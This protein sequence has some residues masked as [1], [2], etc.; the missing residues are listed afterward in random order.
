MHHESPPPTTHRK[1][2]RL[3]RAVP[4][5]TAA[6]AAACLGFTLLAPTGEAAPAERP[7]AKAGQGPLPATSVADV[8]DPHAGRNDRSVAPISEREPHAA[9]PTEA[10]RKRL[11]ASVKREAKA[12]A[13][14]DVNDFISKTGDELVK[15]IKSVDKNCINSFFSQVGS[16]AQALFKQDQ[17]VTAMNALRDLS[18]DYP[19]DNSTSALQVVLYLRAGYYVQFNHPEDVGE[20]GPELKSASQAAQDAWWASSHVFDVSDENGE[21]L[22]EAVILIDSSS[23]NGRYLNIVKKLLTSYDSSY[24]EFYWMLSSVNNV[25]NVMFLG[26]GQD[27]FLAAVKD[28]PSVLNN[29]HDF[30]VKHDDVLGTENGNLV[31]NAGRETGR[32]LQYDELKSTVSP[33]AKDLLGRSEITGRTAPL[34]VSVAEMT[35][36]YDKENCTDY[37]TCDLKDQI[38]DAVQTDKHT[39]SDSLKIVAQELSDEQQQEACT[40]LSGQDAFFHGVVKDNGPVKDD[41]NTSLELNIFNS[42]LDYRTYAGALFGIE[43]DN[44]GMYLEGDPSK[45]G[46]QAR[47]IA[48]EQGGE[49]WNLNHEY[50]H[51]LDGRYNMYGDFQAGQTTP[52]VMWIEGIAEVIAYSYR[53]I[54]NEDAI[55]EAGKKTYRLSTLFDT[56]YENSD[57]TRTYDWGYLAVRYLLQSHPDD[58]A[59]LLG[60]YRAGD[61]DAA[62]TLLTETIGTRYDADFDAWLDKCSAGYCGELPNAAR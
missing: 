50:T 22:N 54:T 17:M 2:R 32:F 42:D 62:R 29:M 33:M 38:R 21:T 30:A 23:E 3:R 36:A 47:F 24:N 39:C 48:Y 9:T 44:G 61:W 56:T 41:H 49:I 60:H 1:S 45:E 6:V 14:C 10:Q 34:W 31:A 55:A 13:D 8:L 18:A 37:G 27:D 46:N 26:H 57:T 20:Y 25:F 35:D 12:A 7:T 19:G 4:A 59:T 28:D 11:A 16:N 5:V 40:S 52:T 43:T 58:V 51:Y 15:Q 53:D